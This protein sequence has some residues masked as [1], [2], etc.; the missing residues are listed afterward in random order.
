MTQ[1]TDTKKVLPGK[2]CLFQAGEDLV[3]VMASWAGNYLHGAS[4][5][6]NSGIESVEET[7]D[8]WIITGYSG[9]VYECKKNAYGIHWYA[10]GVLQLGQ[11]EPIQQEDAITY[12]K[13]ALQ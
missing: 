12:L 5:K 13:N 6:A 8:S 2:W 7:D 10:K 11:L 3:K 1:V 4:W 9:S